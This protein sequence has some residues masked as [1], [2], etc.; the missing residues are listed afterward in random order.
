VKGSHFA[1]WRSLS[2]LALCIA[3]AGCAAMP[4]GDRGSSDDPLEP[5][6]RVVLDTNTAL[7]NAVIKPMAESHR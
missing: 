6:N 1:L 7:D 2:A 4:G 5:V 3:L